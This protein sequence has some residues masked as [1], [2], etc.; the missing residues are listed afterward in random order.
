MI[1]TRFLS[2]RNFHGRFNTCHWPIHMQAIIIH[3]LFSSMSTDQ[4]TRS[5]FSL[6]ASPRVTGIFKVQMSSCVGQKKSYWKL[7]VCYLITEKN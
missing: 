6:N 4:Q 7:R 3:V 2:E 1:Q 5:L